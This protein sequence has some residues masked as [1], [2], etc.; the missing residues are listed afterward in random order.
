LSSLPG[1]DLGADRTVRRDQHQVDLLR[2]PAAEHVDAGGLRLPDH[3]MGL[4]NDDR[5]LIW[6]EHL[7]SLGKEMRYLVMR[8]WCP[9]AVE[10]AS[11]RQ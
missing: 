3:G 9:R 2:D 5:E 11:A 4:L 7:A 6:R 10:A 8:R 1:I